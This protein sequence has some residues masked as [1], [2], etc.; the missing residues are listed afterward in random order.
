MYI[1]TWKPCGHGSRRGQASLQAYH[2]NCHRPPTHYGPSVASVSSP[3]LTRRSKEWQGKYGKRKV[4]AKRRQEEQ[5]KNNRHVSG[6]HLCRCTCTWESSGAIISTGMTSVNLS[7]CSEIAGHDQKSLLIHAGDFLSCLDVFWAG[8]TSKM[9]HSG[10]QLRCCP[11]PPW[12]PSVHRFFASVGVPGMNPRGYWGLTG[13]AVHS[14]ALK[15]HQTLF[16][17]LQATKMVS[18]L[19]RQ[20]QPPTDILSF[21]AFWASCSGWKKNCWQRAQLRFSVYN[22][23]WC[24]ATA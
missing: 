14:W 17:F 23:T 16:Y 3:R 6:R 7:F 21:M 20:L 10:E 4:K 15:C 8:Q 9:Q 11:G 1:W 18:P 22:L 13:L 24:V 2:Q 19:W 12:M 5:R